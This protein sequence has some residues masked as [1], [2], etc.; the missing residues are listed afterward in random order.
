MVCD[1]VYMFCDGEGT[2]YRCRASSLHPFFPQRKSSK[3]K[4]MSIDRCSLANESPCHFTWLG[5][6]DRSFLRAL[7]HQVRGQLHNPMVNVVVIVRL[8]VRLIGGSRL[9]VSANTMMG[10]PKTCSWPLND[11]GVNSQRKWFLDGHR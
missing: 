10:F 7:A 6:V 5:K 9:C 3:Q 11:S 2:S 1:W 8:I 4:V